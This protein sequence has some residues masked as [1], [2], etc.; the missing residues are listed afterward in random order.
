M[1]TTLFTAVMGTALLALAGC[2]SAQEQAAPDTLVATYTGSAPNMAA[3]ASDPVWAKARP[4]SAALTCGANFGAQ[5]GATGESRD[6]LT[7]ARTISNSSSAG[8][9]RRARRNQKAPR[10]ILPSR[11]DSASRIPVIRKPLRT[12]NRSTPR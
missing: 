7:A 11:S 10:A 12:K 3:G 4:L 6:T 8:A 9:K 1:K 2:Q 5:P